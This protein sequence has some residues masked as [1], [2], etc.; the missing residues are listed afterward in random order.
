MCSQT[1]KWTVTGFI[2]LGD[3]S[4][5]TCYVSEHF[6]RGLGYCTHRSLTIYIL[7]PHHETCYISHP[8]YKPHFGE[9]LFFFGLFWIRDLGL[10]VSFHKMA[11]SP[12]T[13]QQAS[14]GQDGFA[15]Y[16]LEGRQ[17]GTIGA[18]H[19]WRYDYDH[20]PP[21]GRNIKE[22]FHHAL[23]SPPSPPTSQALQKEL[24]NSRQPRDEL[25]GDWAAR[26]LDLTTRAFPDYTEEQVQRQAVLQFCQGCYDREGGAYALNHRPKTVKAAKEL[27]VWRK[28]AYQRVCSRTRKD[29]QATAPTPPATTGGK[30]SLPGGGPTQI[31]P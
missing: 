10:T 30:R 6:H 13:F 11:H 1:F 14:A 8:V 27:V 20:Y 12:A 5:C 7:D 25:T 29:V 24:A 2:I 22:D 26:V 17:V 19:L 28:C 15:A 31:Y 21:P 18:D 16:A 23:G 3:L 4:L 9:D